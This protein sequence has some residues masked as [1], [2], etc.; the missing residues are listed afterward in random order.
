MWDFVKTCPDFDLDGEKFEVENVEKA[1][2]GIYAIKK[3]S[4]C[5][6]SL[7]DFYGKSRQNIFVFFTFIWQNIPGFR[8]LQARN[9]VRPEISKFKCM[10]CV[11]DA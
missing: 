7:L 8:I 9:E 11:F 4:K 1:C 3:K 5:L 6:E 10:R 2:I